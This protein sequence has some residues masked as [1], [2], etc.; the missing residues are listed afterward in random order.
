MPKFHVLVREVHVSTMLIE[1][2]T[3]QEALDTASE[4]DEL[5]CEYSH[6]LD[7]DTWSV[8]DTEGNELREQYP[9]GDS[10]EFDPGSK[11]I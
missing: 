6:T 11:K 4:G 3:A 7:T 8:E 10:P 1:A 2:D 5:D 9:R